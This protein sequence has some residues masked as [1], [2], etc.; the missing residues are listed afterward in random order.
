M[1]NF[2]KILLTIISS[3]DIINI[4]VAD[5]TSDVITATDIAVKD[6]KEDRYEMSGLRKRNGKRR[7]VP[8]YEER[9]W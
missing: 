9:F 2:L 7:N 1:S 3:A 5:I 4:T 8:P 6:R